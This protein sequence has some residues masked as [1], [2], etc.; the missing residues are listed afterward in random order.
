MNGEEG[1]G[2]RAFKVRALRM[3]LPNREEKRLFYSLLLNSFP[4]TKMSNSYT[5]RLIRC[6]RAPHKPYF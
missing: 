4:M 2:E 3:R 6:L 1:W 5:K